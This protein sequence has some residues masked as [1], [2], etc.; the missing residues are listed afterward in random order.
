M[1]VI[2]FASTSCKNCY[3]CVRACPV[4]SIKIKD[5]QA[6]I[7]E[8]RCIACGLCLKA[9]PKNIKKIETELD[10]VQS[11]VKMKKTVAVSL[12]PTCFG[13]FKDHGNRLVAALKKLGVTYVEE[14]VVGAQYITEEY[15]RYQQK[16]MG[17]CYITSCCASVNLLIEKHYPKVIPNLIPVITPLMAHAR[18]LKQKYGPQTKVIFIGPCLSKKIEGENEN[19]IDAVLTIE[20][21][22]IWFKNEQIVW[23]ELTDEPLDGANASQRMYPIVG[24]MSFCFTEKNDEIEIV[25]VDGIQDCIEVIEGIERGEFSHK[26][27]ELSAC[28]HSCLGGPAIGDGCENVFNRKRLIKEYAKTHIQNQEEGAPPPDCLLNLQRTFMNEYSPII[29][30]NEK[31]IE[32]ILNDIG[33]YSAMDE[34]NCGSCGYPTC[35]Q[36]AIAVYNGIAEPTMCLPYMKHK[37]ETYSHVIFDVTPSIILVVDETL[38]IIDFN[39]AAERFFEVEKEQAIDL[40]ISIF[41]DDAAFVEV[42]E[43]KNNL[44]GL[45]V[46]LN[47][48]QTTV[49]QSIIWIEQQDVMLCILHDMTTEMMHEQKMQRLKINAIDMAQQ[50]INKQMVVAQQIA[51]LL[52]ET[53]AET[54]VTL[55]RLKQL[56]QEDEVRQ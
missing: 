27:F 30:P 17:K 5:E 44:L 33:K 51:S 26:F 6:T 28:H 1:G 36:K 2:D 50:V 14:T 10:K 19:S 41:L 45:R 56:I 12:A 20:E 13:V 8:E 15:Q 31:E 46:N 4:Q 11:F 55:T 40:P 3:A 54:K 42:K 9:C 38:T 47:E 37:A 35:R 25:S 22:K 53:T 39:P 23:D 48:A 32:R 29:V 34:L 16:W 18:L 43:N 21:L 24:G 52:G 49:I 7:M